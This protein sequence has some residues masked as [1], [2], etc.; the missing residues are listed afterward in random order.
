MPQ[1]LRSAVVACALFLALPALALARVQPGQPFPTNLDT[2]I[3]LTQLTGL[4][5]AL[6]KP[7]CATNPSDCADIDVLNTLDGFS[8]DARVSIPFSGPIDLSTVTPDTVFLVNAHGERTPLD[9]LVWTAAT[10]TLH[11][12]P[13]TYLDQHTPYVLVVT[14]GVKAADGSALDTSSFR[15]SLEIARAHDLGDAL[16]RLALLGALGW[17]HVPA[18]HIADASLYTTQSITSL[19]EKVRRQIDRSYPHP[20]ASRSARPASGQCSRSRASSASQCTG[21]PAPRRS[22]TRRCRPR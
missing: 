2:K 10:N 13:H 7:N 18:S 1:L 16:Y 3:D 15:R 9:R 8:V 19:L 11:G 4:R 12:V 17:S 20:R 6:P 5:V 21:R 14:D 22:A